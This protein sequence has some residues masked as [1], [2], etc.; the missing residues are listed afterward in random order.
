MIFQLV[1]VCQPIGKFTLRLMPKH[2]PYLFA[3]KYCPSEMVGAKA[4][5]GGA[6]VMVGASATAGVM[7]EGSVA[8]L[9]RHMGTGTVTGMA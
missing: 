3:I 6:V 8:V 5:V 7:V 1:G 9:I 4:M 2:Q